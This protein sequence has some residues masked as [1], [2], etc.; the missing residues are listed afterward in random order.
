[1]RVTRLLMG[2]P[3]TVDVVDADDDALVGTVFAH[4]EAV[5]RRFSTYR[6]DSEISA[7]NAGTIC[8]ADYSAEMMEVLAIGAQTKR[9]TRDYFDVRKPDGSLDPSGIVKGW[10]IR[11]AAE[12]I[13]RSGARDFFIDAG[14]DIQVAG[15]NAEGHD[16]RV[17]IRSPFNEAEIIKVVYPRGRG[18]ATS[19][20]YV[21]GQHIYDPHAPDRAIADIVSLTVVGPDILEADRFATAAFAMGREGIGFIEQTPGLEGYLV[22]RNGRATMT[23]GF[24]ECCAP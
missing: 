5:D 18:V 8:E 19:G 24:G 21:R 23:S 3:I 6:P 14:G 16:W 17:G 22:D 11:N 12:M 15:K 4:F 1:M 13:A 9:E 20:T 7:I 10:A 2:M